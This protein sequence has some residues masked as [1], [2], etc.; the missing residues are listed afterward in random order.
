MTDKKPYLA[1]SHTSHDG[2]G[3]RGMATQLGTPRPML[4]AFSLYRAGSPPGGLGAG[5]PADLSDRCQELHR[6]TCACFVERG[7]PGRAARV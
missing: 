7:R 2:E 1:P 3:P 6:P 4:D 5:C